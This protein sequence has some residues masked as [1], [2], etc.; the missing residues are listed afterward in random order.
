M[1]WK[2]LV[3]VSSVLVFSF[4]ETIFPFFNLK[5][6]FNQ[7]I[8]PNLLLG[9]INVSTNSLT[10]TFILHQ[11]WQQKFWLG[12][13]YWVKSPWL[14]VT[15]SFLIIDLYMYMWHRLMHSLL[16]TWQFHQVHHTEIS[17]NTSTAYRFHTVEV[18]LSNIPKLFLIWLLGIKPSYLLFYEITLA[19]ELIFHHSN[20]A[21]PWKLDKLL[22]YIIVTPN[23]HRLHHSQSFP[24]TQSNYASILTIWDKLFHSY[25]YP[26]YPEKIRLG[27]IEYN[28]HLNIINLIFL[29][30]I[31]H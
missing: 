25:S 3:V 27:L 11:I 21:L 18:I 24:D 10:I 5:S 20:L 8:Y 6:S 23:I 7:R 1:D 2:S 9:I 12:F 30:L 28:N 22:S 26:K 15:I 14:A 16:L 31:K 4:L 17:M 29:P 13:L 19:I